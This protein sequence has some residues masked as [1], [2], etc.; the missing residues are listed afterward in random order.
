MCN[1][2]AIDAPELSYSDGLSG[3]HSIFSPIKDH[4]HKTVK[5][6]SAGILL[7]F[8]GGFFCPKDYNQNNFIKNTV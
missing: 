7:F 5:V 6:Y 8:L 2:K 3:D 4:Y 1:T